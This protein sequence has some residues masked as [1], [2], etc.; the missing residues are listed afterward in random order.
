MFVVAACVHILGVIFYAIFASGEKQP[1]ADEPENESVV[2][3]G[4]G[5]GA[6]D[7]DHKLMHGGGPGMGTFPGGGMYGGMG[8]KHYQQIGGDGGHG[9]YYDARSL[10]EHNGGSIMNYS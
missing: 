5:Y 8:D 3:G 9:G 7:M 1:W 10:S 6:V 4:F 2:G